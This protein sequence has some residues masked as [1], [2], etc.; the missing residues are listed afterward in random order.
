[1][2][3]R[4]CI[5]AKTFFSSNDITARWRVRNIRGTPIWGRIPNWGCLIRSAR[6]RNRDLPA[7]SLRTQPRSLACRLIAVRGALDVPAVAAG[8]HP[9]AT[10][11]RSRLQMED[12]AHHLAVFEHVVVVVAPTRGIAALEDQ[13]G[14]HAGSSSCNTSSKWPSYH[15]LNRFIR[16]DQASSLDIART[17]IMAA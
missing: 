14:R 17:I 4:A 10:L 1:M 7:S 3:G 8:P 12:A 15:R 2:R 6:L 16:G 13:R 9:G 11:R 5:L